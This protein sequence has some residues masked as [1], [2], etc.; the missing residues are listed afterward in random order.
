MKNK[1]I[2]EIKAI[3]RDGWL[4]G[5]TAI[6][7]EET[8]LGNYDIQENTF[9]DDWEDYCKE[10]ELKNENNSLGASKKGRQT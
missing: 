7:R 10:K 5:R 8:V 3:F 4:L 9:E 2:D 6:T 1:R